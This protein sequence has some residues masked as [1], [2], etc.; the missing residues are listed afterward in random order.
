MSVQ[1]TAFERRWAHA[2]LDTIFPGPPRGSLPVGIG[3]LDLDG[4]L[5]DTLTTIPLESAVGLRL[6]FWVIAFAPLFVIGRFATIAGLEPEDR[7]R[8]MLAIAGSKSYAIRSTIVALKAVFSLFYFG[9]PRVRTAVLSVEERPEYVRLQQIK[10]TKK[11]EPRTA[12][13]VVHEQ[14]LA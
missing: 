3:D 4:Y 9:D 12:Q 10:T 6:A 5:N 2:A 8:V 1:L 13:E 7:E 11:R 14:R